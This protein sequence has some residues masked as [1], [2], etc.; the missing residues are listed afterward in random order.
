MKLLNCQS[1]FQELWIPRAYQKITIP[2]TSPNQGFTFPCSQATQT[3]QLIKGKVSSWRAFFLIACIAL[4]LPGFPTS[5]CHS[6]LPT[7]TQKSFSFLFPFSW[8]LSI[9]LSYS[10]LSTVWHLQFWPVSSIMKLQSQS[11][12]TLSPQGN[13]SHLHYYCLL[14]S[15]LPNYFCQLFEPLGPIKKGWLHVTSPEITHSQEIL[16]QSQ[17]LNLEGSRNNGVEWYL[18]DNSRHITVVF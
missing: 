12:S 18:S 10:W 1:G 13:P 11:K 16:I 9:W 7:Q 15:P 5:L 6:N 3:L 4:N 14:P 17:K 2:F 8:G